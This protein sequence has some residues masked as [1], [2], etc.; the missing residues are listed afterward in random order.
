M[1][2][3]PATDSFF[4]RDESGATAILVSAGTPLKQA[5]TP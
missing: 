5:T 2:W 4:T 3:H 1:L